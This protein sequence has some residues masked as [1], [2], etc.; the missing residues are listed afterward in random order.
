MAG[1]TNHQQSR[2]QL[3][4]VLAFCITALALLALYCFPYKEH[5]YSERFF[6]AFLA[7]YARLAHALI[8]QLDG[9]AVLI[10]S[11]I[12]GRFA[13]RIVKGCDAME[14]KI[15]FVSAVVAFPAPWRRKLAVGILGLCALTALNVVRITSLYGAGIARPTLVEVLHLEVWPFVMVAVA[16][17]LFLGA[18]DFMLGERQVAESA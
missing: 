12:H 8:H 5:G 11:E 9:S 15:L 2:T 17:L 7:G 13:V 6:E 4:F 10:G 16:A 1:F 14:A 18:S 3:R